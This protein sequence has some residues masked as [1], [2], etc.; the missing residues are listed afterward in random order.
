MWCWWCCH[1]C[2]YEPLQLPHRY[3]Q[4]R[5][6]FEVSGYFCSW[7]CMKAY[8]IDRGNNAVRGMN[9]TL[10]RK[11]MFGKLEPIRAAPNRFSLKQFGGTMTIEEF[12][13]GTQRDEPFEKKQEL[14]IEPVKSVVI[15]NPENQEKLAEIVNSTHTNEPLRLKRNKPLKRQHNT[16]ENSLGITFKKTS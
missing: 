3:D 12:R 9:I 16:L 7:G 13:A 14:R 11:K 8:N 15:K 2:E 6:K 1:E 10:M 4:L 5:D